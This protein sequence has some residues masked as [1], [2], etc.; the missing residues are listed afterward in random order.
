MTATLPTEAELGRRARPVRRFLVV[1]VSL[2]VLAVAIAWSGV[3][4]PRLEVRVDGGQQDWAT[5]TG[6][7][8]G[9]IRNEGPLPVDVLAV[10]LEASGVELVSVTADGSP[11]VDVDLDAR[12][13]AHVVV[14]YR[15]RECVPRWSTTELVLDA[16][17]TPGVRRP[18]HLR[19]DPFMIGPC[20]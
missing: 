1:V 3:A 11:L 13:S 8:E 6:S 10:S 9:E 20:P 14:S 15:I 7:V 4:D 18:V 16:R 2:A 5:G 17:T 19:I 12:G